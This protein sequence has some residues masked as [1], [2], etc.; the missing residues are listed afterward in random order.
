LKDSLSTFRLDS[1]VVEKPKTDPELQ[2]DT[3]RFYKTIF[4]ILLQYILDHFRDRFDQAIIVTDRIPIE[5]KRKEIEKAIKSTFAV[6]SK[7]HG[8]RYD[9]LHLSSKSEINLQIVD[10]LNWAVFKKW[11]RGD[12]RSY[13]LIR[14][15]LRSELE[16]FKS[17]PKSYYE[18]P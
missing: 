2:H 12:V 10:Y 6:W 11:E 3:G 15:C 9:V 16:V 17:G 13:D 4:D 18:Y 8:N 5:K 14:S 1:I 7:V